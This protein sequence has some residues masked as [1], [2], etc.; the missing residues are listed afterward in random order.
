[1]APNRLQEINIKT[2]DPLE[3]PIQFTFRRLYFAMSHVTEHTQTTN[4]W[5][6]M[7]AYFFA[8]KILAPYIDG[9]VK[10]KRNTSTLALE[11]R[12]SCTTPST[13]YWILLTK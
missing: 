8:S 7:L 11:L 3:F 6:Q 4:S 9:L 13:W 10:E 12:L 1:M 5:R 2:K